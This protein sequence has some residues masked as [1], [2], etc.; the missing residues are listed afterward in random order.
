[1]DLGSIN[2]K[3]E[4]LQVFFEVPICIIGSGEY[5]KVVILGKGPSSVNGIVSCMYKEYLKY[6]DQDR[7][8]R[9]EKGALFS[10]IYFAD[11]F[12]YFAQCNVQCRDSIYESISNLMNTLFIPSKVENRQ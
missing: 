5:R 7:F 8:V 6:L 10:S 9:I 1:M 12:L 11:Y 4:E 2:E 3:L